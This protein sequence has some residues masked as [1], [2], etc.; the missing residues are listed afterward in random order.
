MGEGDEGSIK[1]IAR[2]ARPLRSFDLLAIWFGAGI[3][4]AEFWAGALLVPGV[5]LLQALLLIV[6]GHAIGNSLMG[7]VSMEG[8]DVG[9][10]TMVL[11]RKALGEKGSYLP[12]ALNYMQLIGWT[13]VMN[14]VGGKALDTVF[15]SLGYASNLKIWIAVMGMLNTLWALA[16]PRKWKWLERTSAILLLI[17]VVWLTAVTLESVKEID[18]SRG[19]SGLPLL[20][21]LD[22]VVA[23][24]VS[25]LPLVADYSRLSSGAPFLSTFL[26]Y[27][28]SSGLFY[29]V[30][31]LTNSYLGMSDPISIIAAYGLGIPALLVIILS[32]TTTTFMDIYSAAISFKNIRPDEP[33]WRQILLV[34]SAGLIIA[35]LFPMEEYQW[36]L[37]IIGGAFVPLATIMIVD[38]YLV[39]KR[40]YDA[41]ELIGGKLPK[42]RKT[43]ISS[44]A[45]GFAVYMLISIYAPQIGSTI[46]SMIA[47][48]ALY[49]AMSTL[50]ERRIRV[51]MY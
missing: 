16:G 37:L 44:W 12:S 41:E 17:L 31:G 22:L 21:A 28:A 45:I 8:Y 39:S 7:L 11:T 3:S 33:I 51:K 9:V 48:G 13:A 10:P 46:P 5:S 1:P 15:V 40:R 49:Y 36:F 38:Y 35:L 29:F 14:I 47:T 32:T 18:W 30:G 25:W 6:L 43:G 50:F 19:S 20:Q 23:M 26:G 27:F 42:A 34:G 2:N 4:I 24:P